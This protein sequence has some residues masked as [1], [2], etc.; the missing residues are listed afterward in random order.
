MFSSPHQSSSAKILHSSMCVYFGLLSQ[1]MVFR[2]TA[3]IVRSFVR[4]LSPCHHIMNLCE[5]ENRP[6]TEQHV[7]HRMLQNSILMR[8]RVQWV[9]SRHRCR[10][11]RTHKMVWH[12]SYRIFVQNQCPTKCPNIIFDYKFIFAATCHN[13]YYGVSGLNSTD[14]YH[15]HHHQTSAYSPYTHTDTQS[16]V[17]LAVC[18]CGASASTQ[19]N[20]K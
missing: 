7:F 3:I 11:E 1:N 13:I 10:Q 4:Q 17:S 8:S 12:R 15:H 20:V 6:K 19:S 18:V 16:R 14:T 5:F 2:F 9:W